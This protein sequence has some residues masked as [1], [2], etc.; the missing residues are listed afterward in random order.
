MPLERVVWY[1]YMIEKTLPPPTQIDKSLNFLK[2]DDLGCESNQLVLTID[3][4]GI[5]SSSS[6]C[7]VFSLTSTC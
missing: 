2:A 6:S 4:D 1:K 3:D 5:I 7:Q